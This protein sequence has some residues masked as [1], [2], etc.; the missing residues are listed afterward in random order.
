MFLV[1]I[2]LHFHKSSKKKE[3][4]YHSKQATDGLFPTPKWSNMYAAT[5]A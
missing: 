2:S 3:T 1:S 5:T 4:D